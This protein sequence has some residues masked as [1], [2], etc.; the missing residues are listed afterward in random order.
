MTGPTGLTGVTGPT[1]STGVTGVTGRIPSLASTTTSAVPTPNA[2]T[3]DL[4]SL[5][6]QTT[7][8][9]FEAPSG[10]PV[11]GQKMTIEIYSGLTAQPLL[12]AA[13]GYTG[14]GAGGSAFPTATVTS[15]YH[16]LGF[17]YVTSNSL[18]RWLLLAKLP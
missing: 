15:M 18:N 17:M 4:F 9:A 13:T 6:Y 14:A 5:T 7:T 3:T 11:H 1:G 2:D 10:T 8:A 16:H 12:F